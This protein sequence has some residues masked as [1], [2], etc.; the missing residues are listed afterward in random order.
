MSICLFKNVFNI[1]H[2]GAPYA[3]AYNL[4]SSIDGDDETKCSA[5]GS[6][7]ANEYN[8]QVNTSS[9]RSAQS[10]K[11]ATWSN[12][13]RNSS[14]TILHEVHE[15]VSKVRNGLGA[16]AKESIRTLHVAQDG[17]EAMISI[18]TAEHCTTTYANTDWTEVG[19]MGALQG[20]NYSQ[21]FRS[22]L[23]LLF[24]HLQLKT[25]NQQT[26][27]LDRSVQHTEKYTAFTQSLH[28]S[29]IRGSVW[30]GVQPARKCISLAFPCR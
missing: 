12:I 7:W 29:I 5:N 22:L 18:D 30:N 26:A 3:S 14:L 21:T 23:H 15:H 2:S 28:W 6:C 24:I 19:C 17:C 13:R 4:D 8:T 10:V 25:H 11:Y 20:H 27:A 1:G 9:Q 16:H